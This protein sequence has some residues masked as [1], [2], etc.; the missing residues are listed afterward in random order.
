[1][2]FLAHKDKHSSSDV[3]MAVNAKFLVLDHMLKDR[4]IQRSQ[5]SSLSDGTWNDKKAYQIYPSKRQDFPAP[6]TY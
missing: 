2:D 6:A 4:Y 5:E 1:M 3:S